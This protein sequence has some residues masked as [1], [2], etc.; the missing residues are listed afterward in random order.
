MIDRHGY[1]PNVG[2]VITNG[3]GQLFWARRM[4]NPHAWQFPQGGIMTGETPEQ[5][6]Y[7]E[8]AEET[9]LQPNDVEIMTQSRGWLHYRL[10][11]NLI[12]HHTKPLCIGQKQRWY[13]LKLLSQE[14]HIQLHASPTPEFDSWRWVDYWHPLTEVISF[15]YGVY[16]RVLQ[17]FA[18]Y[19]LVTESQTDQAEN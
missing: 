3:Q 9:G 12:R 10:P 13:L 1:R 2:I 14:S 19:V 18:P 7:R 11:K 17:Q 16:K 15:K 5:A 4:G 8:L 6:L